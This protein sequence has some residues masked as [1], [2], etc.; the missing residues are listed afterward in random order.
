MGVGGGADEL[1]RRRNV[2]SKAYST[3]YFT[4]PIMFLDIEN[5]VYC[6]LF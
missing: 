6:G 2:T 3:V 5:K 1:Y 4:I